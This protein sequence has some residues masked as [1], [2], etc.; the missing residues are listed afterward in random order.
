MVTAGRGKES[1][2]LPSIL[3]GGRPRLSSYEVF[4]NKGG[5]DTTAIPVEILTK[6]N[7]R[8]ILAIRDIADPFPATMPPAEQQLKA[9]NK[10]L[11]YVL[12]SDVSSGKM[13]AAAHQ[14]SGREE[15]VFRITLDWLKKHRLSP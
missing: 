12:L 15:E 3:P 8:P 13:D 1:F 4:L 7:D 2:L 5:P 10:N 11:E 14:F 6:V 9:A